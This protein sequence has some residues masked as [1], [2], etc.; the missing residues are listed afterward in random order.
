MGE[1]NYKEWRVHLK[2]PRTNKMVYLCQNMEQKAAILK[3]GSKK[4]VTM[5]TTANPL[6]ISRWYDYHKIC[7][8]KFNRKLSKIALPKTQNIN[9]RN[10][11]IPLSMP[12]IS[13]ININIGILLKL[14][15][16]LVQWNSTQKFQN[17]L[18]LKRLRNW[19]QNLHRSYDNQS[20]LKNRK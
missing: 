15:H 10:I 5:L 12:Q 7:R 17:L 9:E 11:Q 20:Y 6:R 8:N 19:H 4:T 13:R 2:R 1:L 3:V 14:I 18:F 16:G